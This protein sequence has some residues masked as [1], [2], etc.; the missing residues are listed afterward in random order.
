MRQHNDEFEN[1]F[2]GGSSLADLY[3]SSQAKGL[4]AGPMERLFAAGMTEFLKLRERRI[5]DP[6][7]LLDG[8]RRAMRASLQRELD[9]IEAGLSFLGSVGSISPYIGLFGTIWGSCMPSPAGQPAA[10]HAGHRG[11]WHRRSA[12]YPAIGLFAA[13]P[14]VWTTTTVSRA[15]STASRSAWRASSKSSPASSSA[16]PVREPEMAAIQRQGGRRRTVSEINM[17]PFIDVMLVLLII[18][19]VSAPLITPASST[20]PRW[21]RLR[22]AP[23]STSRSW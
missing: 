1:V 6:D 14:A 7:A 8:A 13:I 18:F 3:K 5:A 15:T 9:A 20:C 21:A 2:W 22:A 12:G 16:T 23:R 4:D 17:V 10:G 19:M 11:A